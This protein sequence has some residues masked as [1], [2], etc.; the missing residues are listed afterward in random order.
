MPH[1]TRVGE[2][3]VGAPVVEVLLA[4]SSSKRVH[5]AKHIL[6]SDWLASCHVA[7]PG[8]QRSERVLSLPACRRMGGACGGRARGGTTACPDAPKSAYAP[9]EQLPAAA[10]L[11]LTDLLPHIYYPAAAYTADPPAAA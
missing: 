6:S 4:S 11:L 1:A 10:S 7:H 5:T 2:A 9:T 8:P 3:H